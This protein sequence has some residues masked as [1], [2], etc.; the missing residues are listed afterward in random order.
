M[1]WNIFDL[2]IWAQLELQLGIMC[3][4]APSLRVFFRR[5]M[6]GPVSRA[7]RSAPGTTP[8]PDQQMPSSD[9]SDGSIAVVRLTSVTYDQPV[10]LGTKSHPKGTMDAVGEVE[11]ERSTSPTQSNE[12]LTRYSHEDS[13]DSYAMSDYGWKK[14]RVKP[15][16]SK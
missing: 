16:W 5:Y 15:R 12:R 11:D 10:K 7:F 3:A 9:P 14:G 2:Y 4:S 1:S 13:F 6:D 8:N